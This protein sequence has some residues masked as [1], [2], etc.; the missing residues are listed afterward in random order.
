MQAALE[1]CRTIGAP[2]EE[3]LTLKNL[4]ELHHKLGDLTLAIEYCDRALAIFTEL[5][6]P[7]AKECQELKEKLLSEEG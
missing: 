1:I 7:Q 6:V 3:A 5:G 2:L 4:T